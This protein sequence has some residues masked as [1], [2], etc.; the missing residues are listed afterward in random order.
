MVSI[1]ATDRNLDGYGTP[2]IEWRRVQQRLDQG[3][4]QA[5]G[6]DGPGR[7]TP[8][9]AT[10]NPDGR[11]HVVPVGIVWT[12]GKVF[13]TSGPGTRKSKNLSSDPHCT[14]TIATEQFDIVIEGQASRVT[15]DATLGRLADLFSFEGWEPTVREGAFYHEFSAPSAGPPPWYLYELVL[16]TVFAFGTAEPFGATRFDF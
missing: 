3:I 12:D 4:S 2:V 6:T 7:H 15:D 14:V 11:P 1:P 8:W 10:T 9:L 13:F 5:P 16:E